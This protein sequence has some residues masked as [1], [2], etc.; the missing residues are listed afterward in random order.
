MKVSVVMPT[1]NRGYIIGE[2]VK[3]VLLQTYRELELII[4][5]DGSTDDTGEMVRGFKDERIRYVR[6]EQN[7]GCS[8]A[9]NSGMATA[10]G[11]A[12]AFLDSDDLWKPEKLERQVSFLSRFPQ[13]DIVFTN[14][15]LMGNSVPNGLLMNIMQR[16]TGL[17]T[18]SHT[19]NEYV[20]TGREMYLC[21]LEEIPIKPSAVLFRRQVL[22]TVGQFNE[23]WPSGTDW[24]FFLRFSRS[25]AFGYIDQPLVVQRRTGDATHQKFREQDKLF[26]LEILLKEKERLKQDAE[27]LTSVNRGIASHCVYLGGL[28][29]RS[30]DRK[31]SL[32]AY[33][34]GFRETR[35]P[36][37]L[38][39]AASV[40]VPLGLRDVL[41]EARNRHSPP[42]AKGRSAKVS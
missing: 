23:A 42:Y 29:L 30:G 1:Y 35:E 6:H 33:L 26:L 17:L 8:A 41:S 27:A 34:R 15:H 7:R 40:F 39:R 3:S 20:F 4:V 24:D 22:G 5:D 10:T 25:S 13:V 14:L 31:K 18:R 38:L 36:L 16:F 28:Y 37:M 2:A 32:R 19:A 12:I 11:D 9:Y 21:L